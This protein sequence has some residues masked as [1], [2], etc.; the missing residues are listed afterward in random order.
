MAF[1]VPLNPLNH[2]HNV[3]PPSPTMNRLSPILRREAVRP[4]FNVDLQIDWRFLLVIVL[5][6]LAHR[7]LS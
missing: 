4:Y 2:P 6:Y 7:L 1:V 3:A 5:G